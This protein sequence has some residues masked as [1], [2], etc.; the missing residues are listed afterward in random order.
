MSSTAKPVRALWVLAIA[1]SAIAAAAV[2]RRSLYLL[3]PGP[4]P[5]RLANADLDGGFPQHRVLTAVH[6]APALVFIALAP[7]QFVRRLR[8]RRPGL[9]RWCG[10]IAIAAGVCAGITALVMSP[11]MAVGGAN[12]TAATMVF[13]TLF[14]FALLRA[15]LLIRRGEIAL[16]REWMIRAYAIA[17]AVATVR[18]IV[19]VFFATRRL[20]GL[21]AHEFFGIAFW[22]G[23]T[24]HL[25][26]AE[27]WI[28]YT[29]RSSIAVK[30]LASTVEQS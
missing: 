12:E 14:L 10:R 24:A 15:W 8:K 21:G 26:A 5:A 13:G 30:R 1:L 17:L 27:T 2:V 3:A 7:L 6:I 29:R 19:G 11:Q 23:F 16:H 20:T 28:N 18:P 9:H 25:V 4:A 22:L